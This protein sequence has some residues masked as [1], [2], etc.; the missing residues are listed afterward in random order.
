MSLATSAASACPI[1]KNGN[2][3]IKVPVN[4]IATKKIAIFLTCALNSI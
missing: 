2:D 4:S 1:I 3:T